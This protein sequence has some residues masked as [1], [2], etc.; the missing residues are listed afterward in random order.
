M[1]DK[2]QIDLFGL[3]VDPGQGKRGR[4]R[5]VPTDDDRQRVGAMHA[6]GADQQTIAQALGVTCPTLRLN[7]AAELGSKSKTGARRD[8][9]EVKL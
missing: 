9:R 6:A 7:Y 8:K 2:F 4:P 3:P 5:Y 1:A